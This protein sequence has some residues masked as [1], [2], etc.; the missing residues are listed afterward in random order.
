MILLRHVIATDRPWRHDS[1]VISQ[2][3]SVP[4]IPVSFSVMSLKLSYCSFFALSESVSLLLVLKC[5][6]PVDSSRSSSPL[7]RFSR[8]LAKKWIFISRRMSG[9]RS[10]S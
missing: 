5:L 9:R 6:M 10:G 8:S 1:K 3:A 4:A 2:K 7:A